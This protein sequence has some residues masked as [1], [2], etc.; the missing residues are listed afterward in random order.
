M[1]RDN[2]RRL[3]TPFKLRNIISC[4]ILFNVFAFHVVEIVRVEMHLVMRRTRHYYIILIE[5]DSK[6]EAVLLVFGGGGLW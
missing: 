4:L 1:I 5:P 3:K 6:D 2:I